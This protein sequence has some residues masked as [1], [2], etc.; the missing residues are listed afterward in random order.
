MNN[1]N[2]NSTV[3][4]RIVWADLLR[5]VAI[6]MVICI[7]CS[8]PFNVSPEARSNPEYNLWGSIYGAFLRPCVPL[9]VM[10]TGMLLL[11]IQQDMG[12]FYKKRMMRV[13]VPFL[14]WSLL[15]NLFPLLTG[16]M[17]WDSS[18]L[19]K[20]FAYAGENPSQSWE[21]SLHNIYMIPFNFNV[22]TIPLW[23]IYMLIGLYLF[24]PFFSA[25]L[26]Q[27]TDKQMKV[28]LF[29]WGI[30]LFLPY[31]NEYISNYILGTCAWNNFGTLYYF[32]GFNGYL[33][34]GYYLNVNNKLTIGKTIILSVILFVIGYVITYI[35][36]R[37]M[38]SKSNISEEQME[39]FF[40]YCTPNVLLMTVA[41]FILVQKIQ[42]RSP[43][44][45]SMLSNITKCGLGIY[46]IHYFIVGI[47]YLII[48]KINLPIA[49]QIPTTGILVFI[50]SWGIVS[51]FYRFI[52]KYAK[53]IM[54]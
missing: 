40:L 15:Y 41:V 36:F 38:T 45:T 44:I 16:I 50:L 51:L 13:I 14:I 53:W 4:K 5:F 25:W 27:A 26:K 17:G 24:M 22:Y 42:I 48:E 18:I 37:D 31:C 21:S 35:G 20:M 49:F 39:L 11:P 6:M 28:F 29:I 1:D 7:H 19:T 23:Y 10:L 33:L 12:Q 46:M 2:L 43:F 8:D 54:G 32:A 30:T 3:P 9:F 52:P 47:G 34:L